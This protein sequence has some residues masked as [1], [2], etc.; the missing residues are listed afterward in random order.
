MW[1]GHFSHNPAGAF[2]AI[3]PSIAVDQRLWQEDIEGS[4]AHAAMLAETGIISKKDAAKIYKGLKQI[5]A[6]ITQGA[7]QFSSELE[8]IHMN[9]EAR[10]KE[11]IGE[12]AGKLHTARS[13][14]DQVATDTRLYTRRHTQRIMQEVEKLQQ[15]LITL[16]KG[17]TH[18]IMP[19]MT[20]LQ[21]A[22]PVSFAFYLMAYE[23]MFARDY[24]RLEDALTRLNYCPLG[25]AALAGTSY[26]IN[27]EMTAKALGFSAPTSNAM[28]SVSDRDFALEIMAAL[29][30][31]AMHLSRLAE[32]L[33]FF[34]NPLIGYITLHES[35]TSGSSIMPQK[36][37]A[38]AAE[39][40]RGKSGTIAAQFQNLLM[41]MKGL[42]LAYNKDTQEDKRPLFLA[43]DETELCLIAMRG[44]IET[45]GVNEAAMRKACAL[46]Y[47]NATDLADYL[48]QQHKIPF[49]EA[50][51]ITGKI[52][53]LAEQKN[54][55]LD[56]VS[57]KDMQRIFPE[58]GQA[59]F[60][61]IALDACMMRRNSLGGT[62]PK[63]VARA[64]KQ[65]EKLLAKRHNTL[66]KTKE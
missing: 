50:H 11:I 52:V 60:D 8:D 36:R 49:R 13:R 31:T 39:L 41:V 28:D 44:M 1:G 7:L 17:H 64:I 2:A 30:I 59:V 29:S 25:A 66:T 18:T 26:P 33:V 35:F 23:S 16:A 24:S 12:V 51:H 19:G 43:L 38:D 45:L 40:I 27:R 58:L 22:Q 10:L 61:F 62:A 65:A 57:L 46:G 6:E 42:P 3:N 34:S 20:H 53:K 37:N 55:P 5:A 15:A 9:I 32:E 4:L 21:P 14:N 63:Q 48:V 47:L 56:D 54:I